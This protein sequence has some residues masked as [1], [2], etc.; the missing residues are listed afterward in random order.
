M[1]GFGR[2]FLPQIAG[3]LQ[4]ELPPFLKVGLQDG[5]FVCHQGAAGSCQAAVKPLAGGQI[6][7]GGQFLVP[8]N[9]V[10]F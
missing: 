3:G 4:A 2:I 5:Q 6:R 7:L 8:F 10:A 1:G 9:V